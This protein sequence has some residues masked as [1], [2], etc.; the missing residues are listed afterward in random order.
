MKTTILISALI[1]TLF[2]TGCQNEKKQVEKDTEAIKELLNN[3]GEAAAKGDAPAY[4]DLFSDNVV[5]AAP[6]SPVLRSKE[7]IQERVKQLFNKYTIEID[8]NPFDIFVEDDFA[9]AMSDVTGTRTLKSDGTITPVKNTSMQIFRKEKSGWKISR[10]IY[11][12][13]LPK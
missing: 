13:K 7:E 12:S 10:Q 11:N 9:Y 4:A 2:T 6:N 8:E 3:Y 5:W 1:F